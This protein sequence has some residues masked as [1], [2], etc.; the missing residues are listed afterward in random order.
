MAKF[1]PWLNCVNQHHQAHTI[2]ISCY[3]ENTDGRVEHKATMIMLKKRK[4]QPIN[5]FVPYLSLISA[6]FN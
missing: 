3:T 2:A 6:S 5:N 1:S 4:A